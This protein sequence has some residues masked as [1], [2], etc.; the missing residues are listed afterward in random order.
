MNIG[1]LVPITYVN[2]EDVEH[3][4]F[5]STSVHV[6]KVDAIFEEI[7]TTYVRGFRNKFAFRADVDIGWIETKPKTSSKIASTFHT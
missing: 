7:A 6:R 5:F 2:I 4:F 1:S 3:R